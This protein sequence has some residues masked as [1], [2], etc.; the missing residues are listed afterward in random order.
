MDS[1]LEANVD[2]IDPSYPF[3]HGTTRFGDCI[4]DE[5]FIVFLL[6][7]ITLHIEGAV[8]TVYDND[9][10]VLLI[11]AAMALPTWLDPS[12]SEH[13]VGLYQGKAHIIPL[14]RTPAEL[15][16]IP[17]KLTIERAIDIIRQ[18][19]ISTVAEDGVQQAIE[20]RLVDKP[21]LHRAR[22][23]L[24]SRAAYVLLRHPQLLPLAVEAFYL[25]DPAGLKACA[26]MS[27]FPP[28]SSTKVVLPFTRTTYAQTVS[29]KFYA[30]KAFRLP[31]VSQKKEY[32]AAELGMKVACGLEM[33]YHD[34]HG[35][36]ASQ[37]ETTMTPERQSAFK[38]FLTRLTRLG[39]FR[40]ERP[41]SRL[42]KQLTEQARQQF[43]QSVASKEDVEAGSYVFSNVRQ[44]IDDTLETFS[45][46]SLKDELE[47]KKDEAEDDESWMN[48]DPKQLEELLMQR[49]GR[50]QEQI[51]N[52]EALDGENV[53]LDKMMG[54]FEQFIEGSKSG[55]EGVNFPG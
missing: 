32:H 39:Y 40:N 36:E 28:V 37:Q 2:I 31:P 16:Q 30:P 4:Q 45:E 38:Q 26:A 54:Q 11:E 44:T 48:V 10:D 21:E 34:H 41:G 1:Y 8:A 3:L 19:V 51:F 53:D 33:L 46:E 7:H 20:D 25:R 52:E 12:N 14:P 13:R 18:P 29:Q 27:T 43:L 9:G 47:A 55:L 50:M 6:R 15:M 5:W 35:D 49:M 23:T 24:P 17:A 42:H 22:C